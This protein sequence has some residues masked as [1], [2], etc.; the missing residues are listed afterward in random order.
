MAQYTPPSWSARPAFGGNDDDE[1]EAE[2]RFGLEVFKSGSE[3]DPIPLDKKA[4][5]V[6]GRQPTS[7]VLLDHPSIS[8]HHAVI[9]FTADPKKV[10]IYD[11]GSTHGTFVNK[12][13]VNPNEH[14]PV[15][16]RRC[17]RIG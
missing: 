11:L 16:D 10:F 4:Y 14:V 9:Q 8:R 13:R 5:Y 3:L 17:V 6:F 15:C 7:D 2:R 1:D 12:T